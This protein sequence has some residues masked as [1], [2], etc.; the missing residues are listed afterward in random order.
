MPPLRAL[1]WNLYH[2]RD[3][4][5]DPALYTL[6]SRLLRR[7]EANATHLQ[8]NRD[9]YSEFAAMLGAAEWDVAL[10]QE[11][12][13]RWAEPLARATGAEAHRALTSRNS[14]AA[15]R[16]IAGAPQSRPD[17]LQRGGLQPHPGSR[18]GARA[19]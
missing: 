10:L 7:T 15:I 11:C 12:P 16:S 14:L 3:R 9:L 17:R 13:P 19:A 18:R 6:R 8:V 4:P 5:P 2:G 1:S